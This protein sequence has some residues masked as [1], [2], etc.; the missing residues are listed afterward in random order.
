MNI[1][2]FIGLALIVSAGFIQG[3]AVVPMKYATKW[4][5]EN[6]WLSFT[7]FALVLLPLGLV[8]VRTPQPWAIYA[9]ASPSALWSALLFGLGW[10]IGMTLSGIGYTL[11]GMGLGVSIVL[12]LTASVGSLLPL[13]LLYPG[14]LASD[15]SR[16]LYVGVAVMVAGLVVSAKAGNLRQSTRSTDEITSKADLSSF[17][18]GDMRIGVIVCVASGLLSSMVNLGL[19]FGDD[20]RRTAMDRGASLPDAVNVLWLPLMVSCFLVNLAYCSYLLTKNNT[21]RFFT[22][23]RTKSGWFMGFLMG[24]C[25]IAGLS[26]YGFGANRMGNMGAIL[27]F[28]VFMSMTVITANAAGWATGEWRG[29]PRKAYAYGVAGLFVLV[30]AILIIGAGLRLVN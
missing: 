22:A 14:R 28:P 10:G 20:I 24:T 4:R 27:G 13:L 25:Q 9:A 26:M 5:W 18:K 19:V 30:V 15:S 23:E 8:L 16:L 3:C 11:L 7:L 21:W 2:F 17:G 12:G 1:G 6:V 29:S